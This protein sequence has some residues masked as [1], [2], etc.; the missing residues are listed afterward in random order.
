MLYFWGQLFVR[1]EAASPRAERWHKRAGRG[2]RAIDIGAVL[3][4]ISLMGQGDMLFAVRRRGRTFRLAAGCGVFNF[5]PDNSAIRW[6]L[7]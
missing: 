2:P 5:W 6:A 4:L 7:S 3:H 1:A